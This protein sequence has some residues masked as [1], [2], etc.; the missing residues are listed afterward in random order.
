[1]C[2]FTP[3]AFKQVG[4]K[5]SECKSDESLARSLVR[6]SQLQLCGRVRD[7]QEGEEEKERKRESSGEGRLFMHKVA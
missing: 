2:G 5:I 6:R 7:G 1:M 3:L 4:F